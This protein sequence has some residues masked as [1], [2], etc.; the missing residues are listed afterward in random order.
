M[1][2]SNLSLEKPKCPPAL[3]PSFTSISG[4]TLL[5]LSQSFNKTL[6]PFKDDIIGASF[7][8]ESLAI[9]GKEVGIPA[10]DIII[11]APPSM[12]AS[13]YLL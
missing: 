4:V 13:T 12:A 8:L 2:S 3:G 1:S 7:T 11:S 9:L 10:P 5:C 6:A